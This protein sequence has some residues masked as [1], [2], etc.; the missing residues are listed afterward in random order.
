MNGYRAEFPDIDADGAAKIDAML[1]TGGWDDTSWR[2]EPCPRLTCDVFELFIDYADPAL[3]EFPDTD[4]FSIHDEGE[5]VLATNE[6]ADVL[7]FIN[8][9]K[10]DFS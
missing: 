2:N 6:W 8:D 9:G 4:R 5:V 10:R 7:A 1:A 3:R